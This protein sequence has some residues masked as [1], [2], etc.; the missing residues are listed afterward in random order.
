MLTFRSYLAE[1]AEWTRPN[2]LAA[3]ARKAGS[4][5]AFEHG[6]TLQIKRGIY[7]HITADAHFTIDASKGPHDESSMADGSMSAGA[8][9]VTSD[10]DAW[11]DEYSVKERPY[12]ALIDLRDV[13]WSDYNQVSRGF[14]NEFFIQHASSAKVVRMYS[15]SSARAADARWVRE[16]PQSEAE[17]KKFY[18]SL[19][20]K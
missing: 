6:W 1:S 17:L 9:M 3:E 2:A 16:G 19:G 8:L 20:L 10:L 7:W 5:D 14:G 11:E 13:P 12:V 4:F 15:R 18:D